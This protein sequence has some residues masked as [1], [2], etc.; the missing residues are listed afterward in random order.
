MYLIGFPHELRP[1]KVGGH[2]HARAMTCLLSVEVF[3]ANHLLAAAHKVRSVTF[4]QL[5]RQSAI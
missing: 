2:L 3:V 4:L 1:A 5:L